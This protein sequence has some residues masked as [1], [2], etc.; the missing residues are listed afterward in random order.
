LPVLVGLFTAVCVAMMCCACVPL[1]LNRTLDKVMAQKTPP[2]V[3][4]R[5]GDAYAF[6]VPALPASETLLQL[7]TALGISITASAADLAGV[8]TNAVTGTLSLD[9]GMQRLLAGTGL[10][11]VRTVDGHSVEWRRE[12]AH[13][14]GGLKPSRTASGAPGCTLVTPHR[15]QGPGGAA[16]D[17]P[18]ECVR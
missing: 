9:Q 18:M 6:R 7:G 4:V 2:A 10:T 12:Q 3:A 17:E 13:G 14:G 8:R 1:D 16:P 11:Y 15:I 5:V